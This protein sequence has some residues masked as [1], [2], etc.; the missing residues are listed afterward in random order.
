MPHEDLRKID[1]Q[2]STA[3]QDLLLLRKKLRFLKILRMLFHKFAQVAQCRSR[4]ISKRFVNID[5]F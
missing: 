1:V 2:L 3:L 5:F 4:F